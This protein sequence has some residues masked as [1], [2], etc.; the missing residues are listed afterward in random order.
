VTFL[1]KH[2]IISEVQTDFKEKKSNTATHCTEDT[3]KALDNKVFIMGI[4]LDSNY[5][6]LCNHKLLLA[7]LEQYGLKY[8][9]DQSNSFSEV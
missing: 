1:N 8:R 3:Q 7:K 5:G 4:F 9:K 6:L 2:N